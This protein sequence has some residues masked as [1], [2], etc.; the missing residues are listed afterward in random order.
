MAVAL[1]VVA[2]FTPSADF[3]LLGKVTSLHGWEVAGWNLRFAAALVHDI[4][5]KTGIDVLAALRGFTVV[6]SVVSNLLFLLP[7]AW[8]R[9]TRARTV[10]RSVAGLWMAAMALA[11][12]APFV[13]AFAQTTTLR[14]GYGVW[15]AA[16]LALGAALWAARREAVTP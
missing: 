16:W 8:L 1:F 5:T 13:N 9:R 11:V 12:L 15:L 10:S 14:L 2:L 4:F 3:G 7:L 6:L